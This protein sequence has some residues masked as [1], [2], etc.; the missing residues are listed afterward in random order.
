MRRS[1]F[2]AT[3]MAGL[4]GG[5]LLPHVLHAETRGVPA[6]P[7]G[8]PA[9]D[10]YWNFLRDQFPLSHERAYLNT[11]GLGASPYA[12]IDAVKA[13]MDELE[14]V[15]ETGHADEL[16]REIK[17]GA[18]ALFG[19]HADELAFTRNTTE[20]INIVANG[21]P[22]APGDEVILTT[23]EHVGNAATWVVL[24]KVKGVVLKRFEPSTASAE[25]NMARITGLLSARTR[26]IAIPHIVTTTGLV[27]PV[28][29][30]CALVRARKIW[31]FLDGAQSAGMMP[32]NLHDIGCDAY[33][34]SGHKWLLGPK[35]TGFLYVRKEM[36]DTVTAHHVGAYS[37]GNFD[38]LSD[39]YVPHPTAQRYEY[40]T[41]SIPLRVVLG[42]AVAF[43]RRI[44]IDE[45]WKRDRAL[46]D[47][48]YE[49]LKDIP[50]VVLLSSPDAAL[51]SAMTTFMHKRRPHLELQKHLDTLNL[52][53][54]SVT[55]GGLEA[56]RIST[57]VYTSSEEVDR[58]IAGVR[59][60]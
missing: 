8:N 31:S 1:E 6:W 45:I 10:R 51:R 7:A 3:V 34:T 29:E 12:V 22:F 20:G 44:G 58:V 4:T 30:I 17:T 11:G 14:Q 2:L 15:S 39:R 48:L 37:A 36:L 55:E 25:E 24:E 53:T 50:D 9:D 26:L 5:A 57:H 28:R 18:A 33:A 49:G 46:A 47:R 52:R 59:T 56:L 40:G 43:I 23:H 19:C 54:R 60:A 13:K 42:A 38:F 41:V 35:E 16:L 27:M 32:F 21:L